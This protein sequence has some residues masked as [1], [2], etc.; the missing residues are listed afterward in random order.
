[1]FWNIYLQGKLI[2]SVWYTK[3]CT[4]DYVKKSLVEHDGYHPSIVV[5]L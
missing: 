3:D 1:M 2:D 5:L 4:A